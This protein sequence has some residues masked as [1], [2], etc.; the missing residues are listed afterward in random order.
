M[1]VTSAGDA[2][3]S[4]HDAL[5]GFSE[6]GDLVGQFSDDPRIVDPRGLCPDP[7][8]TLIY[9]NSAD[10]MLALD[11]RGLVVRDSGPMPGLDP[12]GAVFGPDGRYYVTARQRRTIVG[13]SSTLDGRPEPLLPEWVVP[14]PRGFAFGPEDAVYLASG[15]G[16]NGEGENTIVVFDPD[17]PAHARPVVTDPDLS[18]LDLTLGPDGHI[19][20]ASES[21]FGAPDAVVTVRE[22][23]PTDGGLIR[24]LVPD[25]RL[26]FRRPR[27]LRLGPQGHLFCVGAAHVVAF[28]LS[29]GDFLGPVVHMPRLQ[30]QA[31]V[32]LDEA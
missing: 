9:L 3:G 21:P 4:G 23:D 18:P 26:N 7:S 22:Y 5:L 16:P 8:G 29:N 1:L 25:P 19:L 10:R 27:G 2:N 24:V 31:L 11:R 13:I 20:V 15:I 32:L 6:S 30:G 17:A 28:D 14:F 12:G